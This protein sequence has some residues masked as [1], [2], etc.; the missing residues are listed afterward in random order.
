MI[1]K[2]KRTWALSVIARLLAKDKSTFDAVQSTP[3]AEGVER[4][5]K[6]YGITSPC[7][8]FI[9]DDFKGVIKIGKSNTPHARLRTLQTANVSTLTLELLI[10]TDVEMGGLGESDLH[11]RFSKYR[12]GGE[13][14]EYSPEIKSFVQKLVAAL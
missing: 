3:T 10:P 8:Y 14:F 4:L 7:T 9:A 6:R 12:L 2:G 13:W 1:T 5:G 11:S